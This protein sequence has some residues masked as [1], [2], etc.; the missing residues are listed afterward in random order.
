VTIILLF[1]FSRK[2]KINFKKPVHYIVIVFFVLIAME[3]PFFI[4]SILKSKSI[5]TVTSHMKKPILLLDSVTL[6]TPDI[7]HVLFDSYTNAPSLQQYWNYENEIYPYL[8]SKGFYTVDSGF[9]NYQFTPF[10]VSS[11]FN[12]QYLD[13]ARDYLAPNSAN[14]LIGNKIF[15]N[16]LLFEFLTKKHYRFSIY[17][18]LEDE[19]KLFGLG[20]LA[21]SRPATWLRKQ[22]L[23]RVYLNPWIIQKLKNLVS[24]KEAIPGTVRESMEN[25]H[26]YNNG[27]IAHLRSLCRES[28]NNMKEP[29]FSFTHLMLP[30]A[31]YLVDKNGTKLPSP[32]PGGSDMNGY[33][34]QL[35]Y[36]N[37]LIR[38]LT[39]CLLGDTTKD[40]IIIFQGDHGYR[41]HLGQS[42]HAQFG[43]L[44][45]IFL[46]NKDYSGL[47]KDLSL[48]NTYRV[49]LNNAFKTNLSILADSTVSPGNRQ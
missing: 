35:K 42:Y 40:K 39:E 19:N 47:R 15:H 13:G 17:S 16:N 27:A 2:R 22:T 33:L 9:S 31:P 11:L 44:N 3:T 46:Y 6:E 37:K 49:V 30:H 38:E 36:C 48:V 34:E 18:I 41:K 45:A 12:L 10:S 1:I 8:R 29:R 32:Q 26:E 28:G 21:I 20:T 14:F 23:E 24:R 7:Y 4:A 43:S 5:K 25:Y